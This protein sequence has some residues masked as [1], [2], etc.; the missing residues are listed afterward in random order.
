MSNPI[1]YL[2]FRSFNQGTHQEHLRKGPFS[3]QC[4]LRILKIDQIFYA[5]PVSDFQPLSSALR[6]LM[7]LQWKLDQMVFWETRSFWKLLGAHMVE[8]Q[9]LSWVGAISSAGQC[10]CSLCVVRVSLDQS[11]G[12]ATKLTLISIAIQFCHPEVTLWMWCD[13]EIKTGLVIHFFKDISS[14]LRCVDWINS[15]DSILGITR[16]GLC[17]L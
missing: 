1:I 14:K 7:L 2:C 11:G 4:L 15:N 9:S 16:Q 3:L 10:N 8:L 17:G 6:N 5:L 13:V 12:L